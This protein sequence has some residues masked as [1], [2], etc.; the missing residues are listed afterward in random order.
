MQDA[1]CDG[2]RLGVRVPVADVPEQAGE[3]RQRQRT[4]DLVDRG[5]ARDGRGV[6]IGRGGGEGGKERVEA[7]GLGHAER[8]EDGVAVVVQSEIVCEVLLPG[9]W[10]R[11][12]SGAVACGVRETHF[13]TSSAR[14]VS[15]S[16]CCSSVQ[17]SQNVTTESA[18]PE[19]MV[20]S[21]LLTARAQT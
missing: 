18:A 16:S 15:F 17:S 19:T 14:C 6:C 10:V 7:A 13:S 3:V 2:A 12:P 4:E 21:S 1:L 9:E 11:A 20:D 5:V 8:Q